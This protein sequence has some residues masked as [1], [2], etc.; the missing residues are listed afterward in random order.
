VL[1]LVLGLCALLIP[2]GPPDPIYNG[3]HLSY[4]LRQPIKLYP[5]PPPG[6]NAP[7]IMLL[8]VDS[9]AIPL[10]VY[11]L[12][13]RD[14]PSRYNYMELWPKLPGWL[15]ACLPV[16]SDT[17]IIIRQNAQLYLMNLHTLDSPQVT[18]AMAR[19]LENDKD[20]S[21][22]QRAAS[23]LG[24]GHSKDPAVTQTLVRGLKDKDYLVRLYCTNALRKLDPAALTN[25]ATK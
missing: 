23:F 10:L 15:Q 20:V 3:K 1:V 8:G 2:S 24:E 17:T 11:K 14:A 19:I 18:A 4:W 25:A 12:D 7:P 9:N 6:F 5:L 21:F 22:R 16:P 13:R